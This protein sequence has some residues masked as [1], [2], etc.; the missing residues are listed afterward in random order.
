[1][2]LTPSSKLNLFFM[3]S[4]LFLTSILPHTL[5]DVAKKEA[6]KLIGW[7]SHEYQATTQ[8]GLMLL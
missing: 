6:L 2:R 3:V 7:L 5:K 8:V 1:M 4:S